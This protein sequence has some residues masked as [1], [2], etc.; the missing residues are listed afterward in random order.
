MRRRLWNACVV[1]LALTPSHN[2]IS[3]LRLLLLLFIEKRP[4][5]RGPGNRCHLWRSCPACIRTCCAPPRGNGSCHSRGAAH[6]AV[7]ARIAF[8]RLYR[9]S[10]LYVLAKE[11][12]S[13][14]WCELCAVP[15]GAHETCALLAS[16]MAQPKPSKRVG[17]DTPHCALSISFN[18]D[19]VLYH[20]G[21]GGG[22]CQTMER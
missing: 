18:V 20:K 9:T 16:L 21:V 11:D 3:P 4:R 2:P 6:C 5:V 13:T 12:C 14:L 22:G 7:I 19:E 17:L 8:Q 15:K 1:T 10:S